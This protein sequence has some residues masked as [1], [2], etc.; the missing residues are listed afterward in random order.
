MANKVA[1]TAVGPMVIAAVE[2]QAPD[3]EALLRDDL[4]VRVLPPGVRWLVRQS[5]RG[6]VR[7]WLIAASDKQAPGIWNSIA[8][9]KRYLDDTV[10]AAVRDGIDTIVVL[11]AGLDTRG[12]R[13]ATPAGIPVFEVDLPVNIDAKRQRLPAADVTAVPIDF[14]TEDLATV[15]A[16]HGYRIGATTQFVWEG[17]TQYLTEEAVR[18]TL[19]VS[20]KAGSGSRLA[21]TYVRRDFLDGVNDYGAQVLYERFVVKDRIWRFGLNL[22]EVEALLAEYGWRLVEQVGA[23]QFATRYLTPIGRTGPV[24][25]LEC[26]VYAERE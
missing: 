15:L 23:Q 24:S 19:A 3:G 26:T 21:F 22:G 10:A 1:G 6:F 13:L 12:A 17:V 20:A 18:A 2:N 14:E 9:R 16:A 8:C 25:D 7:R 4:A 5:R 11:G